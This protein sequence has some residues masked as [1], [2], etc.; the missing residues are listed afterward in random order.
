[1]PLEAKSVSPVFFRKMDPVQDQN[2]L[3]PTTSLRILR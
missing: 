1:M 2:A 3:N